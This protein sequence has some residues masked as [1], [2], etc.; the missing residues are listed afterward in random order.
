MEQPFL[1]NLGIGALEQARAP[2]ADTFPLSFN[3]NAKNEWNQAVQE[4]IPR[5]IAATDWGQTLRR[6]VQLCEDHNVFPFQTFQQSRN[7]AIQD[8]LRDRR[9][10]LVRF[11]DTNDFFKGITIRSTHRNVK[12]SDTGFVLTVYA[13]AKITDPTFIQWIKKAPAP[14]FEITKD[15][16]NRWVRHITDGLLMYV[17]NEAP[18]LEERWHIGYEIM[19]P[20]FPELPNN[21]VPSKQEIENFILQ[22]LWM[23]LI[24]SMRPIGL[25]HRLI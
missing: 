3:A 20:M 13:K 5:G 17:E 10:Q 1:S 6:Y 2:T 24:K 11:I 8:Y 22:I 14:R 25:N 7:D 16:Q 4:L 18:N 12:A 9:R 23:P 21:H 19:C 15:A